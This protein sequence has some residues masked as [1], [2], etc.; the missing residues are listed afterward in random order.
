MESDITT[1]SNEEDNDYLLSLAQDLCIISALLAC[2][3]VRVTKSRLIWSLHI[4]TLLHENQFH[5]MYHMTFD[6]FNY[7]L[8]LLSPR[9]NVNE[10][11]AR[12]S[13]GAPILPQYML[14]CTPVDR[15]MTSDRQAAYL[16]PLFIMAIN[17][18]SHLD[19]SLPNNA[20][21]MKAICQGFQSKSTVKGALYGCIGSLDCYLL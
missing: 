9:L 2:R 4:Q 14:S 17:Q 18:C 16:N 19:M 13:S 15:T 12:M 8:Q 6:S 3:A 7:L 1:S 11:F 5:F 21:E 10:R 20:D